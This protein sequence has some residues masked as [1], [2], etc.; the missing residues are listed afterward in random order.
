ML[1]NFHNFIREVILTVSKREYLQQNSN[2][3][4]PRTGGHVIRKREENVEHKRP[5]GRLF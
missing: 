3:V 4:Y 1:S 5:R 2:K